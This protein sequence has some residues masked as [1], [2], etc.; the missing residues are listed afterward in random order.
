MDNKVKD[1]I[2]ILRYINSV[3]EPVVSVLDIEKY[4]G[5]EKLRVFPILYELFLSGTLIP[6]TYTFW[7]VPAEYYVRKFNS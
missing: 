4:S 1:R 5:A 2:K 6:N 7:G 3:R